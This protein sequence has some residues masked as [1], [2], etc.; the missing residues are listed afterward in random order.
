LDIPAAVRTF[1]DRLFCTHISDNEGTGDQ[2]MIPGLGRG[3]LIPWSDVMQAF[4]DIGYAGIFNLEIPG[5]RSSQPKLLDLN[6]RHALRVTE[7]LV[8]M[9]T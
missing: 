7:T 2:H 5:A 8:K 4:G 6:T 9:A 3:R 1:G